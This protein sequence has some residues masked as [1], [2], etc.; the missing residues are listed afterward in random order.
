MNPNARKGSTLDSLFDELGEL[1]DVRLATRKKVIAEQLRDAMKSRNVTPARMARMMRTSRPVVY[2]MLDPNNTG[3]TLE[4]LAKAS[5][6]LG[7]DLEVNLSA[8]MPRPGSEPQRHGRGV[9][10]APADRARAL[11][12]RVDAYDGKDARKAKA[13]LDALVAAKAAGVAGLDEIMRALAV[14]MGKQRAA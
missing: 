13:V 8:E 4:T 3:L 2:R 6:V 1:E 9:T 7:L 11:R 12:K 5:S 14:K 10:P